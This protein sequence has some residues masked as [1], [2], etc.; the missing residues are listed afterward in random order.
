MLQQNATTAKSWRESVNIVRTDVTC[1]FIW[2]RCS[3]E[4]VN[5]ISKQ[6]LGHFW[7]SHLKCI[8]SVLNFAHALSKD[9]ELAHQVTGLGTKWEERSVDWLDKL[10][11]FKWCDKF[12]TSNAAYRKTHQLPGEISDAQYVLHRRNMDRQE[13]CCLVWGNCGLF[14]CSI[15]RN[16]LWSRIC[17]FWTTQILQTWKTL[18]YKKLM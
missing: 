10:A 14:I 18:L 3:R 7:A 1:C 12:T 16:L 9:R 15:I 17:S 11:Q 4:A 6:M 13:F 5:D 2:W 8:T